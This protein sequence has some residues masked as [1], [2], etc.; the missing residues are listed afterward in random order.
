MLMCLLLLHSI[1]LLLSRSL[2]VST[3]SVLFASLCGLRCSVGLTAG[4]RLWIAV[5]QYRG[6]GR[7]RER[8]ACVPWQY[9]RSYVMQGGPAKPPSTPTTVSSHRTHAPA[10]SLPGSESTCTHASHKHSLRVPSY[11]VRAREKVR[12]ANHSGYTHGD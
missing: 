12:E 8:V 3:Y 5:Q 1:L 4:A 7:K 9:G 6:C 2:R 10:A 11:I